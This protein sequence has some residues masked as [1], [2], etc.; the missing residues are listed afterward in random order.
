M[1][2]DAVDRWTRTEEFVAK[3][4]RMTG[5]VVL[6][7]VSVIGPEFWE[8]RPVHGQTSNVLVSYVEGFI[9]G[10]SHY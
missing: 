7:C 8:A 10:R 6:R 3:P 5:T 4:T 9:G 1:A 2:I